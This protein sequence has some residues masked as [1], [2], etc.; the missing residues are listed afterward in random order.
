MQRTPNLGL[1]Q[2][3]PSDKYR[4]EDYNEAYMKIDEKV[5]EL[6]DKEAQLDTKLAEAQSIIDTW[7]QFKNNGG[8]I[9]GDIIIPRG[10]QIKSEANGI[11]NPLIW[12]GTEGID[13]GAVMVGSTQ[14]RTE[15]VSEVKPTIWYNGIR[16][17]IIDSR[18]YTSS[19]DA[20]GYTKLPNG[21]ILQ[22]GNHQFLDKVN[23]G[24]FESTYSVRMPISFPI[25]FPN[26]IL[27]FSSTSDRVSVFSAFSDVTNSSCTL[28]ATSMV[29][30]NISVGIRWIAI[31]Y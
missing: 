31:G 1:P 28:F 21:L 27:S 7:T 17:Y 5:K 13:T 2:F 22:W 14:Q 10:R 25:A 19:K 12:Q 20:N 3:E 15:I 9:C 30:A 11:I 8:E 29:N 16:R 26:K 6:N 23:E 18:D 4:L 24:V